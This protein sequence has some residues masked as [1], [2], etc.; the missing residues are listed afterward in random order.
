MAPVIG[1]RSLNATRNG[2]RH[3]DSRR[4]AARLA[5]AAGSSGDVGTR[6]ASPAPR[7]RRS[8][9]G[10]ARRRPRAQRRAAPSGSRT[11]PAA[12]PAGAAP[13][14]R[15]RGTEPDIRHGL[16]AGGQAR[17]GRYHPGEPV[18]VLGYQPQPDQ[19]GPVLSDEG[20][21]AQV[22]PVERERPN[23]LDVPRITVVAGLGGL[24]RPPTRQ[25]PPR[26]RAA[27]RRPARSLR[28][29][30]GMTSSVPR[31]A[32]AL[33]RRPAARLPRRRAAGRLRRRSA[34][35]KENPAGRRNDPRGP[36]DSHPLMLPPRAAKAGTEAGHGMSWNVT[37]SGT[38][39]A[40][41]TRPAQAGPVRASPAVTGRPRRVLRFSAMP[42]KV[43]IVTGGGTGIGRA[44]AL[45]LG[46]T[47][48]LRRD[49]RAG[50]R[51]G[52]EQTVRD[53]AADRYRILER[54]R[55]RQ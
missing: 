38:W 8:R 41:S 19:S 21:P 47:R 14:G 13:C 20:Q 26:S 42:G 22:K 48:I 34:A 29:G 3:P 9:P 33:A 50:G 32:A 24:V 45:A 5:A 30:R 40:R 52:W 31:A 16:V 4:Q 53:G 25:D 36:Q 51:A 54:C 17:V 43:A 35:S 6:P 23:P 28:A 11:A 37:D 27:R 39:P 10:T 18:R 1:S 44:S 2:L 49:R 46:R 12:T 15:P 7:R 55:G